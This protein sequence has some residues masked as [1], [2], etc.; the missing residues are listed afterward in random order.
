M[1]TII[2]SMFIF[3]LTGA[4]S[5]GPVNII[6]TGSGANFG[7]KKTLPHIIGASLAYTIIVFLSGTVLIST[8]AQFP[9]ALSI[10]QYLGGAF[11]LYM[12]IKIATA[13][14]QDNENIIE[15]TAPTI[16]EGALSQGLNP[17]AWLVAMS[18]ITLFVTARTPSTDYLLIF[19]FISLFVCFSGISTWAL[20]GQLIQ[21]YLS[22]S[23]HQV[24]FN[25]TMGLLLASTVFTIF[26][27]N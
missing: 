22:D 17:K 2:I 20:L 15:K 23:K 16:F 26:S 10:V 21:K 5:P 8:V 12:S 14:N 1:L 13:K 27:G 11:L 24:I 18:G 7:F 4:I 9:F 19:C 25:R 3:A 6:A